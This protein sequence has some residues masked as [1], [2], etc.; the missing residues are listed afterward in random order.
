MEQYRLMDDG[1]EITNT[2]YLNEFLIET[3][4]SDIINQMFRL[5]TNNI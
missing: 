3:I 5:A 4:A 2:N 1:F